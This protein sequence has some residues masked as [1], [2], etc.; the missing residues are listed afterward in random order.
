MTVRD[1]LRVGAVDRNVDKAEV[2]AGH[3]RWCDGLPEA[4]QPV[5]PD[6]R[7]PVRRRAADAGDRPGDDVAAAAAA[8]RRG[9]PRAG[10]RSWCRSSSACCSERQRG[11]RVRRCC[12][13]SRTP[14]WPSTS[15]RGSTCSRW[16]GGGQ[17]TEP[18]VPRQ[19]R[20]PQGVPRLLSDRPMTYQRHE[21]EY[22]AGGDLPRPAVL[23]ADRR[24]DLR[25][26]R[27]LP[28]WSS[29][30]ASS[31]INFA[32]GEFALFTCFIAWWLT[33]KGWPLLIGHAGRDAGRLR[34]GRRRRADPHPAGPA[35]QRDRRADRGTR[36]CSP[37]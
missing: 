26:D 9:Q 11:V 13:S 6:R 28:W 18:D 36:A 24:L 1:N 14:N 35:A 22:G 23:R 12:W 21:R 2:D 27:A 3:R 17:R 30:A 20:H 8:L 32:Q 34:D 16:D 33:T 7:H 10:A 37:R 15:R 4:R 25:A 29:S 19:R 31:T 5:E